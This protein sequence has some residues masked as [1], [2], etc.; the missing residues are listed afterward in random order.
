MVPQEQGAGGAGQH[1]WYGQASPTGIMLSIFYH[2]SPPVG[3]QE[4]A[5][6][7]PRTR[8]SSSREVVLMAQNTLSYLCWHPCD[9]AI[10]P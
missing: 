6:H 2:D 4:S 10:S 7:L 1:A 5:L 9:A 3:F 8:M